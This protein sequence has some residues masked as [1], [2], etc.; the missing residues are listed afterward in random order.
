MND[1]IGDRMKGNYENRTRYYLPRRTYTIVRVDGKAF[2]TYCRGLDR[3]FDLGLLEDMQQV[4]LWLCGELQGARLAYAQSDEVSV[5]LTDFGNRD[6]SAWFDGNVQKIASVSAS[7]ATAYLN[8]L[9]TVRH[10]GM[11]S[12]PVGFATFDARA[13][14]IPEP[15]EVANY[16]IWRQRD[17][18]RNSV[19][20][21]ARAHMPHGE[22]QERN[23]RELQEIL[24][25]NY[26]VNWNDYDPRFK[27]GTF[28]R[29]VT[30]VVND[31]ERTRWVATAPERWTVKSAELTETIPGL[32]DVVGKPAKVTENDER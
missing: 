17:A 10:A 4:A 25:A 21:A 32:A 16:L 14:T 9:R 31:A 3:P 11:T 30:E 23:A 24:W 22:T 29:P 19:S 20:L 26:R 7:L 15:H 1:G 13:F 28:V 5:L 2:H 27:R 6:T 18:T 8:V 12:E